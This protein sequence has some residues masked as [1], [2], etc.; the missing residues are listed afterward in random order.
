MSNKLK[1]L[2][3]RIADTENYLKSLK[4]ERESLKKEANWPRYYDMY[5]HN[6]DEWD[7]PSFRKFID[8]AGWDYESDKAAN[9][10]NAGYEIKITFEVHKDGT[11]KYH[12]IDD[13]KILQ[14]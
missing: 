2:N 13:I 10:M 11:L 14:K 4:E 9:L 3:E 5:L 12:A 7:Q 8:D 6:H 1:A